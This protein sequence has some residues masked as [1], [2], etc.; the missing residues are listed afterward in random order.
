MLDALRNPP[1]PFGDVIRTHFRLKASSVSAQLDAWKSEDDSRDTSGDGAEAA[2][3]VMPG[4]NATARTGSTFAKDIEAMK[5]L[6]AKL[7]KGEALN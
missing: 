3:E 6:L 4:R 2:A 1:E 7:Q 5:Q